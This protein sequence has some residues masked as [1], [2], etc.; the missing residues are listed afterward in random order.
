MRPCRA[1]PIL[2]PWDTRRR[3]IWRPGSGATIGRRWARRCLIFSTRA[4]QA[5]GDD[6]HKLK[7]IAKDVFF[8]GLDLHT[9]CRYRMLDAFIRPGNIDTLDAGCGNGALTFLAVRK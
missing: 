6:V 5:S 7:L 3:R 8:P 4:E 1:R 2:N 9:R